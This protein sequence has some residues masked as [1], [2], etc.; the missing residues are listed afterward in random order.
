[1]RVTTSGLGIALALA[2]IVLAGCAPKESAPPQVRQLTQEETDK[3]F[4]E[5]K[6]VEAVGD[7]MI[8]TT[9][10]GDVTLTTT[11]QVFIVTK[12]G[13]GTEPILGFCGGQCKVTVEGGTLGQCKTSGCEPSGKNC[14]PL[15]C[16]GSCTLD[17]QCKREPAFSFSVGRIQ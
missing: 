5:A 10:I 3:I 14:T 1:M 6:K 8:R 17:R 12:P 11:S 16:S 4:D 9:V 15:V 7:P 13:G 2:G